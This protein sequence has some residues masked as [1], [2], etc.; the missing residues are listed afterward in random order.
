MSG[1]LT[2]N[3]EFESQTTINRSRFISSIKGIESEQEAKDYILEIKKRYSDASSFA[4][5]YI[6]DLGGSITKFFDGGEPQGTAGMPILN[7][8]KNKKLCKVVA[9]VTRYFGGIKLGAGGLV[10]AFSGVTADCANICQIKEIKKAIN[11]KVYCDYELY[12]K[13]QKYCENKRF[14]I[15]LVEYNNQIELTITAEQ[16]NENYFEEVLVDIT[17]FSNGKMAIER[18]PDGMAVFE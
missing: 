3:G 17:N 16:L 12:S 13:F 7:V 14:I 5:A 2:V 9:V 15:K 10:R 4:Y 8:L 1:F 6:A 11:F 18:L